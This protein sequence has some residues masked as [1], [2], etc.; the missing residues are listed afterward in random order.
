MTA[1]ATFLLIAVVYVSLI[2]LIL[3]W[4]AVGKLGDDE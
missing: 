1:L 2:V 4:F 3:G